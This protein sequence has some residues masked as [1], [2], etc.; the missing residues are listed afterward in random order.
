MADLAQHKEELSHNPA[1]ELRGAMKYICSDRGR[2]ALWS[3]HCRD[4]GLNDSE[5]G[6]FIS[7][8]LCPKNCF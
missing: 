2:L 3:G 7:M 5:L 1:A 6:N 4:S 8:E